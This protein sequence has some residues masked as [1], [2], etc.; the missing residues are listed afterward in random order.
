[1]LPATHR[2]TA[3]LLLAFA[4]AAFA[5]NS[6]GDEFIVFVNGTNVLVPETN[7][8]TVNDPL[9]PTSGNQVAKFEFA[10]WAHAA[11]RWAPANQGVDASQMVGPSLGDGRTL[12]FSILSDPANA[13]QPGISIMLT[14]KTDYN[15]ASREDLESGAAEA[16]QEFRLL[17]NVPNEMHDGQWHDV[18]VQ[19][20]PDTY[21]ALEAARTNG[22]LDGTPAANWQYTGAWSTGGFGIGPGWGMAPADD[23][24][25]REFE[26]ANLWA[27]GPFW[28]HNTGTGGP[29]Y[30]DN[31]YFGDASTDVSQAE[32]PPAAMSGVSFSADGAANLVSWADQ[33]FGGYNVYAS[34][35]PITDVT[36]DGVVLLESLGVGD[37]T[38]F[39]HAYELPHP[40]LGDAP[41][42][43]A[44]TS[45]SGFGVENQDVSAS[46][47]SVAN[48]GLR[49]KAYIA[50]LTQAQADALFD[51]IAA[52]TPTDAPFDADHPVFGLNSDR[53]S[54]GDG[55]TTETLP[56]DSDS[57]GEFKIGYYN[58]GGAAELYIFGEITDD[59][60][61]IAG[62]GTGGADT[63]NFDSAEAVFGHYDVRTVAGGGIL[64]GSP[65][66]NME[67]GD[68]PDYGLRFAAHQDATG[69]QVRTSTWIGWSLNVE[70]PDATVVQQ[71]DTGWRFLTIV[72]MSQI[73]NGDE[74]DV[75][76]PFPAS[77]EIQFIPFVLSIND[78]DGAT[79]ET[80]IIWSTKPNVTNQWWNT[81][82]MWE[83][84]AIA[85]SDVTGG[86]AAEDGT[87]NGGFALGAAA[88]NPTAGTADIRF[89]LGTAGPVRLEVFNM[90]GQRVA[91]PVDGT[92]AAGPHTA[93]VDASGLAAGVY[94]YR[95]TAGDYVAARRMTVVR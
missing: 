73:Q 51:A 38:E 37:P 86:T 40:S 93:T 20:P 64:V 14:D 6:L 9:D 55:T 2:W 66:Q 28:D 83:T 53:R 72:D 33:G 46:S 18:A 89:A 36:A 95:L 15:G 77:D 57:S 81:P 69:N 35:A 58:G 43:Y 91:T 39:R 5:Q 16:D 71:T 42:H 26:W 48:P 27:M 12:Y 78:A 4:P 13:D 30:L 65:H 29:I 44:V 10:S 22:D 84:V 31:V 32:D 87:P 76:L 41:L 17:W 79:R 56:E 88:P 60:F 54:P 1:M 49:S 21:A 3:L 82:A 19:L 50:Q 52:G 11:F 7:G 34:L 47:G 68:E 45:L 63:W 8:Q 75:F 80:Q 23:P 90:L 94:V 61:T 25:W 70:Q 85:G 74:G 92:F 59:Q 62:E 24:L 67:R